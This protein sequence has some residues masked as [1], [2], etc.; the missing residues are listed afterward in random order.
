MSP[1]REL[2]PG[3]KLFE[4]VRMM[5]DRAVIRDSEGNEFVRDATNPEVSRGI[6]A[7]QEAEIREKEFETM[8]EG[9]K[10]GDDKIIDAIISVESGGN[11]NAVSKK[12]AIG[13]MQ[14][15]PKTAR[16]PGLSMGKGIDPKTLSDPVVNRKFGTEYFSRLVKRYSGDV[17]KA[18]AA[19][20][21]GYGLV[22][23]L[24][25][26]HGEQYL[27]KMPK[28]TRDYVRKVNR[29]MGK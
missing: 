26:E 2:S 8:K 21:G 22:D 23:R 17:D 25:K 29:A 28:E 16:N 24:I 3:E 9:A 27:S 10:G 11:P 6:G 13:L 20:N 5:E 1:V 4:F 12:G 19:Y 7:K 18:L 14:I 15:M